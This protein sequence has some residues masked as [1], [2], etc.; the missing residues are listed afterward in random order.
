MGISVGLPPLDALQVTESSGLDWLFQHILWFLPLKKTTT[1]E[2]NSRIRIKTNRF[3]VRL[4]NVSNRNQ[5]NLHIES[6]HFQTFKFP[7]KQFI[8]SWFANKQGR[9]S[10]AAICNRWM[11]LLWRFET[12][13]SWPRKKPK[14]PIGLFRVLRP[15]ESGLKKKIHFSRLTMTL[16]HSTVETLWNHPSF[17]YV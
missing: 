8:M 10:P 9:S 2:Q 17:L 15:L 12:T 16:P 14:R 6:T 3:S 1:V 11:S 5:I 13:L 4:Q 7:G